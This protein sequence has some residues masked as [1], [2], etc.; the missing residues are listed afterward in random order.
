MSTQPTLAPHDDPGQQAADAHY[1]R[2]VLHGLIDIGAGLANLLHQQ[3]AA[4]AQPPQQAPAPHPAPPPAPAPTTLTTLTTITAAFDGA[5]RSVRRC[6]ALARS[7]TQPA[8]PPNHSAQHRAAARNRILREVEDTI[9]RTNNPGSD[10]AESLQA[11][12][13]DRLDAPDLDDD[14]TT[15]PIT[16]IIT[17]I[18]RDL[19][20]ASLPGAHP[21]KRRTP[22]DIHQ[23]QA[24]AAAPSRPHQPGAGP[25]PASQAVTQPAPPAPSPPN[26]VP[27]RLAAIPRTTAPTPAGPTPACDEAPDD[28]ADLIATILHH[29]AHA[30]WR[31]P[32]G[33]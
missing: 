17:E 11:E 20:L 14:L 4:Q 28:A 21:W 27:I 12:L 30:R 16:E 18:C 15:R 13:H 19:G 10:H 33:A 7:L 32:P 31:P 24:R 25:Q 23:L 9:Q 2:E 26:A 5:S 8:P 1:Y 3:A 6:I 22:A 29:P